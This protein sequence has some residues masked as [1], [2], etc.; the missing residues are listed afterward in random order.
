MFNAPVDV[1]WLTI[2]TGCRVTDANLE[3]YAR[4]RMNIGV[5]SPP[6]RLRHLASGGVISL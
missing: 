1:A 5:K 3:M 2:N 6:L 4:T